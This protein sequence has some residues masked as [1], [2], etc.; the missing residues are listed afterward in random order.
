MCTLG[1]SKTWM[2]NVVDSVKLWTGAFEESQSVKDLHLELAGL[3]LIRPF[4]IYNDPL[5]PEYITSIKSDPNHAVLLATDGSLLTGFCHLRRVSD[6]LFLNNIYIAPAKR[7]AG[8]GARLL[9]GALDLMK[10][11][12]N[13]IIGLDVLD[14]NERAKSWYRRLGFA[15]SSTTA[16]ISLGT[17]I[18][19]RSH[20]SIEFAK[21]VNGFIQIYADG[22]H[23]GTRLGRYAI[24][25][26]PETINLLG[27]RDFDDVA[28]RVPSS[29][30]PRGHRVL[31]TSI[32]MHAVVDEVS[33]RLLE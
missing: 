15:E 16:W 1:R 18:G 25:T 13:Q 21:D 10:E 2:L 29:D 7:T 19:S 4:L 5:F 24:V 26:H 23:Q 3:S 27:N 9:G 6:A 11:E 22:L 32:R 20:S 33:D 31:E 12:S 30:V 28:S 17:P 14:S 8:L